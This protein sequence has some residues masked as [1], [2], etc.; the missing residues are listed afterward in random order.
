MISPEDIRQIVDALEQTDVFQWV[1]GKMTE[2]SGNNASVPNETMAPP[3]GPP[4]APPAG[5]MGAEPPAAPMPPPPGPEA[6]AEP[7][8][9]PPAA[10]ASPAEPPPEAAG[11]SPPEAPPAGDQEKEP[12]K[13][14][15]SAEEALDDMSDEDLEEYCR[16]RFQAEGS[17]DGD[18]LGG[19][20]ASVEETTSTVAEGDV[21]EDEE[22]SEAAGA[23]Q[24]KFS[25]LHQSLD[26]MQGELRHTR[27]QLEAE[28]SQRVDAERY[29]RLVEM[30]QQLTFDL[31]DEWEGVRYSKMTDPQFDEH[32]SRM[33]RNYQRIPLN[34]VLPNLQEEL[35]VSAPTDQP[36]AGREKY[37]K[38]LSERALRYCEKKRINGEDVDYMHVLESFARGEKLPD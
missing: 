34:V 2:E 38:Q 36:A 3:A 37:S 21:S 22:G 17:V 30:R 35:G 1:K 4:A 16:Q 14:Y 15:A 7:P 26:R 32:V 33:R 5:P 31:A 25:R 29:A 10:P 20:T 27:E 12:L 9:P 18:E 8:T 28:R 11:G 13:K 6:G 19:A 24:T 23:Y